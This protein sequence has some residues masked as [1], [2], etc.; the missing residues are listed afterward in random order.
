M[1][2]TTI[3]TK[4][5]SKKRPKTDSDDEGGLPSPHAGS[6]LSNTPPS[7]KRQKKAP[8]TKKVGAKPLREIENEAISEAIDASILVDGAVDIKAK[9]GSKATEQYQKVCHS[10]Q[11]IKQR[12][13]S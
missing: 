10:D 2:Q 3:K 1:A 9:K 13:Q 12:Q 6:L 4:N 7:A 5:T 8:G 11:I